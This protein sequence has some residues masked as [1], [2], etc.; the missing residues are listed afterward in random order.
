[1]VMFIFWSG[2]AIIGSKIQGLYLT[3]IFFW[4][5]FFVPPIIHY[6]IPKKVLSRALPL[7]EQLDHS[8]KYERRSVLD[9][10]ELLV[11]VKH[12]TSEQD[13]EAEEDEYLKS[14]QLNEKLKNRAYEDTESLFS[15]QTDEDEDGRTEEDTEEDEEEVIEEVYE[16]QTYNSNSDKNNRNNQDNEQVHVT[17][18]VSKRSNRLQAPVKTSAIQLDVFDVNNDSLLPDEFMPNVNMSA[19]SNSLLHTSNDES[20]SYNTRSKV[21]NIDSGNKVLKTKRVKNR[22]NV[23][24]YYGEPKINSTK[25]P[26]NECDIDETFDFLDEELEKY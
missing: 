25:T 20:F 21:K 2:T 12:K 9:K 16:I 23:L 6:D 1:M 14:F 18:L 17:K 22:P 8:M 4:I 3:Y 5:I 7:L 26:Q 15:E 13:D 24:D 10:S 19:L 11:N